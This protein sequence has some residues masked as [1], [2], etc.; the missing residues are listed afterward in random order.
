MY[1]IL[2]AIRNLLLGSHYMA[3]A[4]L[5][6]EDNLLFECIYFEITYVQFV[7]IVLVIQAPAPSL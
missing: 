2:F 3:I 5:A 1:C 4:I 7:M 6:F